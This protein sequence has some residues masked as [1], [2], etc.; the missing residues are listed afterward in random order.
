MKSNFLYVSISNIFIL[1]DECVDTLE[2]KKCRDAKRNEKCN[3]GFAQT[4]CQLTCEV[5][6]PAGNL[7]L[8]FCLLQVTHIKQSKDFQRYLE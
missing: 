6:T 7:Y 8:I 1:D 5:C 3:K 4:G 2:A